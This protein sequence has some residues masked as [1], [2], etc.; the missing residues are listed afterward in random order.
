MHRDGARISRFGFDVSFKIHAMS[1]YPTSVASDFPV[2]S[3][4]N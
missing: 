1:T 3:A 2:L 4:A